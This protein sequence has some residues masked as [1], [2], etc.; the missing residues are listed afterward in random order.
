MSR[1]VTIIQMTSMVFGLW[2]VVGACA[3]RV[4]LRDA[5]RPGLDDVVLDP[6]R[7]E[8]QDPGGH[9]SADGQQCI[10][11][12]GFHGTGCAVF[13]RCHDQVCLNQ[14]TCNE[15]T[16]R[17]ECKKGFVG[18]HCEILD[19]GER[20]VYDPFTGHCECRRGWDG[21]R[22]DQC[23][24]PRTGDLE[25]VCVPAKHSDYVLLEVEADIAHDLLSGKE[26]PM[27]QTYSAFRPKAGT[28]V[29]GHDGRRYGCDCMPLD[30]V[31]SARQ[32]HRDLFKRT[33][34][35]DL[36]AFDQV[37]SDCITNSNLTMMQMQDLNDLWNRC[38]QQERRGRL[39]DTW[40]IVGVVFICAFI[41]VL[42][43]LVI[44][45]FLWSYQLDRLKS[46]G[47]GA[48]EDDLPP[49]QRLEGRREQHIGRR[50]RGQNPK[51]RGQSTTRGKK[52]GPRPKP[53]GTG[54]RKPVWK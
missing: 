27:Q 36:G 54:R 32:A 7:I 16:G 43:A 34:A 6:S 19:C 3:E 31:Q 26:N 33:S 12:P 51:A 4:K 37:I 30:Y 15:L 14:G 39:S 8:C 1:F 53:S 24:L 10:C 25:S 22:C 44:S 18:D 21:Y 35:A 5:I 41:V 40:Y 52:R 28:G 11:C 49:P 45:C 29:V 9:M 42:V 47:I 46:F 20:G 17:C 2:L 38:L 50:A 13:N 48:N 23:A